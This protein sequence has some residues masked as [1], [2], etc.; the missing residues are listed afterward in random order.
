MARNVKT[1]KETAV[2]LMQYC[3]VRIV[4]ISIIF[5]FEI[6]F[7]RGLRRPTTI[8]WAASQQVPMLPMPR[9]VIS[10]LR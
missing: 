8:S 3:I 5:L 10:L 6:F 4:V 9:I 1:G 2:R 7:R